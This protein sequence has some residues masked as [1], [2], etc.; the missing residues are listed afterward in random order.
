MKKLTVILATLLLQACP[1][2]HEPKVAPVPRDTDKCEAAELRLEQLGCRD[3]A[4]DPMWVNR[5]GE[6][7]A[8]TCQ[9]AQQEGRVFLNPACIAGAASCEKAASCPA[10]G[11]ADK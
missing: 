4:G 11:M 5:T 2:K 3:R 6:R 1:E 7:F 10:D 8:R 9:T